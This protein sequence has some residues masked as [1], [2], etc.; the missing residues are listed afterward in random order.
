MRPKDIKRVA[1][2]TPELS[3]AEA[4]KKWDGEYIPRADYGTLV[5]EDAIGTL[6]GEF[7]FLFL[8]NHLFTRGYSDFYEQL[9][10]LPFKSCRYTQRAALRGS[11]GGEIILGWFRDRNSPRPRLT[12]NTLAHDRIYDRLSATLRC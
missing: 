7:K 6:D 4:R 3:L 10:T 11:G 12:V 1:L 9:Q 2:P 8:R 5:E